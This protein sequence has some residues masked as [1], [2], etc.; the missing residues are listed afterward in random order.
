MGNRKQIVLIPFWVQDVLRHNNM[1]LK[2]CLDFTKIRPVLSVNDMVLFSTLQSF[3]EKI[4]G[5]GDWLSIEAVW[6]KS[7]PEGKPE[8]FDHF[9]KQICPL[10]GNTAF[11][12][13][14]TAR[15]F[16]EG[17]QHQH[18]PL[19]YEVHDL[20]AEVVGV[21]INPGHFVLGEHGKP[22]LHQKALLTAL[23]KVLYVYHS[24]HEVCQTSLF[25]RYLE[26]L[27]SYQRQ[28]VGV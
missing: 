23:L 13:E 28:A 26:L 5:A 16:C 27:A 24:F 19:P 14:L 15:L 2:D 21:V 4:T 1:E 25:R 7:V 10:V 17:V 6:R 22:P 18:R 9:N 3:F 11:K 8:L 12:N 20:S